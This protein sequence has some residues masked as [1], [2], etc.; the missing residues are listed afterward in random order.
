[1][2]ASAGGYLIQMY[3][4]KLIDRITNAP[5]S[6]TFLIYA[7]NDTSGPPSRGITAFLVERGWKGFEV[8]EHL[9]KFG[10]R[11]CIRDSTGLTRR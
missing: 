5:L 7:K 8:G 2:A 1:M 10:A 6:S 11:P 4:T 9:D 3:F